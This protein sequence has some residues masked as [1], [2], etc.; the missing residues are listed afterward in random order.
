MRQ[1]LYNTIVHDN[2]EVLDCAVDLGDAGKFVMPTRQES[3]YVLT[4]DD[5]LLYPP[6]YVD[7]TLRAVERYQSPV[8]Y[9]GCV[10]KPPIT[11]YY[12]Q[13]KNQVRCV[14]FC[15]ADVPVDVLGTGTMAYKIAHLPA[16]L[17]MAAF[18]TSNMADLWFALWCHTHGVRRI[19]LAHDEGWILELPYV[20][21]ADSI[22]GMA[23]R[24]DA[25]QTA[26]ANQLT[27]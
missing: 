13:R 25:P 9:H 10:I 14:G 22:W 18:Q 1:E 15:P 16:R 21:K 27:T 2:V 23:H 11:S 12:Q 19:A 8:S 5:E 7:R 24:D 4:C 20:A 6:D 26:I 17:T 3:G